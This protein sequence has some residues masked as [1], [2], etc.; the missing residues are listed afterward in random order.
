MPPYAIALAG[1]TLFAATVNGALG[2][3]FSSI[4][5]PLA[6]LFLSNRVLNPALIIIEVP[7]NAWVLWVNRDAL[8]LVWRRVLPIIV[9]LVPGIVFG[10]L[11]VSRVSPDWL[12]LFTF[13]A[14]LPL[15][16]FQAAG[17]RRPIKSERSAGLVFGSGVG[18]LYSVTTISGPPLAIA[19]NNQGLAKREFRAALGVVRLAESSMT[20]ISY[21]TLSLFTPESVSLVPWI[22][23]SV[24]VGVPIGAALIGAMRPETFRR[25]CMSFD[26][27]I[28]GFGLSKLMQALNLLPGK[29][30]YSILLA[31][32][33]VDSILLYRF[34]SAHGEPSSEG[35]PGKAPV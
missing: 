13:V 10:S 19:L 27:W 15:I 9:G 22:V 20:A 25:L 21:L 12:K 17:F 24:A 11:M 1:I 8:P 35:A 18:L 14:L 2:Y 34:F 6:L 28:V 32:I 23:P 30:G 26:A 33:A 31:V 4:T 16:L 7:L 3:G 5:V 29:A